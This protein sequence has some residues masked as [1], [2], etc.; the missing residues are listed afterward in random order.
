MKRTK[1]LMA[2]ITLWVSRFV[3]AVLVVLLFTLPAILDWYTGFRFLS[4]AEQRVITIAFYCCVVVIGFA[5]W[6]VDSLLRAILSERVFVR[7]NV[8]SIRRIQWCCGLVAVITG[9]TCFAYLPLVFLAVI[10]AFL[11][12][13]ISVVASVMDAAVTLQEENALTI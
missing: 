11:C 10:M 5:L 1:N 3:A 2:K 7:E 4:D 6:N 13:M 9:V 8:R 12:L